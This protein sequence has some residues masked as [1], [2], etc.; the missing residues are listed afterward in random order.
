MDFGATVAMENADP[1]IKKLAK[2]ITKSNAEDGVA[3]VIEEL[4]KN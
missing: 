3:F 2:Y 1:E 4:L